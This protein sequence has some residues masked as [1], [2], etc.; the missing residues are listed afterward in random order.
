MDLFGLREMTHT[1]CADVVHPFEWELAEGSDSYSAGQWRHEFDILRQSEAW[2]SVPAA[3]PSSLVKHGDVWRLYYHYAP[4]DGSREYSLALAE[5][6]SDGTVEKHPLAINH[7]GHFSLHGV[8][9]DC[10]PLQANVFQTGDNSYRMY[11]W[12][13]HRPFTCRF[14]MAESNDGRHFKLSACEPVLYHCNNNEEGRSGKVP[15]WR[16]TNDATTV[17]R[18]PD[19]SWELYTA[20][21]VFSHEG[22]PRF[23]REDVGTGPIGAVRMVERFTSEDGVHWNGLPRLVAVPDGDD[24]PSRQFYGL[25]VS[26]YCNGLRYGVL[27]SYDGDAQTN[28]FENVVSTDSIN[29]RRYCRECSFKREDGFFM[30]YPAHAF[31]TADDG[32]LFL[33]YTRFNHTHNGKRTTGGSIR[34]ITGIASIDPLKY[35]IRKVEGS[36]V[37][38]PWRFKGAT[39][40]LPARS[41]GTLNAELLDVFGEK[42]QTVDFHEADGGIVASLP[43][44]EVTY[45]RFRLTGSFELF[46]GRITEA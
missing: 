40:T 35:I 34:N 14:L 46:S 23:M 42:P 13:H 41:R 33:P 19:G 18:M 38:P 44:M 7:D 4:T 8:P 32:R 10:S 2:E 25:N 45:G 39:A 20:C 6:K 12:C 37:S 43:E 1:V 27:C 3:Y 17:Y 28:D 24:S 36:V 29:Y 22:E 21:Y 16:R 5:Y 9:D 15:E 31:L 30:V 26:P 11:F